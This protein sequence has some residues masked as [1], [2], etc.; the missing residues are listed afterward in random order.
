MRAVSFGGVAFNSFGL[1]FGIVRGLPGE[2]RSPSWLQRRGGGPLSAGIGRNGRSIPMQFHAPLAGGVSDDDVE[3]RLLRLLG[4]LDLSQDDP[5][6]LVAEIDIDTDND[7]F[8]DTTE[9]VSVAAYVGTYAWKDGGAKMLTVTFVTNDPV[10]RVLTASTDS[11]NMIASSGASFSVINAGLAPAYPIY[12]VGW[13]VQRSGSAETVG[14][15]YRRRVTLANSSPRTEYRETRF[16]DLG[17]TATLVSNS[18]ART[19]GND[20][21]IRLNGRELPRTLM[22]WNTL[23]TFVAVVVTIPANNSITLDIVYGNPNAGSPETL[24]ALGGARRRTDLFTAIDCYAVSGTATSGGSNTLTCSALSMVTN[25]FRGGFMQIV[26]GTGVGQRRRLSANTATQFTTTRNWTTNPNS[27]SV[28]VVWCSGYY[29]DG[30]SVSS[31]TSTSLTDSS[32]TYGPNALIGGTVT[33]PSTG[34][35]RR[36]IGNT[37]TRIDIDAAWSSAPTTTTPYYVER[38]GVHRY[39][40]DKTVK[41]AT[42]DVWLGTWYQDARYTA[43]GVIQTAADGIANAWQPYLLLRN[44]DAYAQKSTTPF[45]VGGGDIDYFNGLDVNRGPGRDTPFKEQG[46]ADGITITHA[47][48]YDA[49]YLDYHYLNPSGIAAAT[50]R[51][52]TDGGLE[53][54]PLFTDTTTYASLTAVAAAWYDLTFNDEVGLHLYLGLLPA[55]EVE[56]PSTVSSTTVATVRTYQRLEVFTHLATQ[57]IG[58]ISSEQ[59]VYDL[60]AVLQI[61]ALTAD[62]PYDQVVLGGPGHWLHLEATEEIWL[63]TDP[64]STDPILG[65]YDA[66]TGVL[67]RPAPWAGIVQ[68]VT[69]DINGDTI[70]VVSNRFAPLANGTNEIVVFEEQIGTLLVGLEWIEGYPA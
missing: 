57:S 58:A 14:W 54:Q 41:R 13:T 62:P 48:G 15:R 64:D 8:V 36:I 25:R 27:T 32:Q 24:N 55:D 3:A 33:V 12:K 19:D 47:H 2:D 9:T 34:D 51:L 61:A 49:A 38:P 63:R 17:D 66:G 28:F 43:P 42:D 65:I 18:K 52:R 7:G 10:W 45:D 20:L 16:I 68:R 53:W 6:P 35:V 21:R 22:N 40:V 39:A 60:Q 30:G 37:A 11:G 56:I 31:A 1:G 67:I 46:A 70:A 59:E 5:K 4:S 44:N 26:G 29:V 50:F 23:R 69:T